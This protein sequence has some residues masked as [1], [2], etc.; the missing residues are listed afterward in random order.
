MFGESSWDRRDYTF[1]LAG[2]LA[3]VHSLRILAERG[4]ASDQDIFASITGIREVLSQLPPGS[5]SQAQLEDL[6]DMLMK[7]HV[8]AIENGPRD[9]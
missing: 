4:I 1:G 2:L 3:G 6:E 5:I 7:I 9:V 8:Q